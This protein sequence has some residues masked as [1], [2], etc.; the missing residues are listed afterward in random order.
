MK[1]KTVFLAVIAA[2]L[3]ITAVCIA[4]KVLNRKPAP[5][6]IFTYAENQSDGYPTS[7]GAYKFAE[8]V[9]ERSGGRIKIMV[10]TS[11]K[12]GREAEV[13][14]QMQYGGVDFTRVSLSQ[15][16]EFYPEL[17]VLQMPFLYNDAAHMWSVL[18]GEIGEYFKNAV[19][20]I[21]LC[22]LSWY[23]SGARNFYNSVRPIRTLK[24]IEGLN[25]RVQ[26]SDLMIDMVN[27]LGAKAVPLSYEEVYSALE[28]GT[29]DGAEN[30]WPSYEDTDHYKVARYFCEDEHTRVPEMQLCS[31]HTWNLLSEEDRKLISECAEESSRY[32]R[33][34]WEI[35]VERSR[36]KTLENG[37]Q[38]TTLNREETE[39]IRTLMQPIYEKYCGSYMDILSRILNKP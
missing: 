32:E 14:R 27:A 2:L 1:K 10:Y 38:V 7:M 8:L 23:E 31:L 17:N 34:M 18:E 19:K 39:K 5:E 35:R 26:Q 21:D 11:A 15:L 3:L 25:I 36:E 30:N 16:A 6:Y 4:V 37:V 24:D 12:L 9:E 22:G 13:I 33:E 20:E 28:R 29:I